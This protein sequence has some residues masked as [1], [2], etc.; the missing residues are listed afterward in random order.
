MITFDLHRVISPEFGNETRIGANCCQIP[1]VVK[2]RATLSFKT[3]QQHNAMQE[4]KA[5]MQPINEHIMSIP[6][7]KKY[8]PRIAL[9]STEIVFKRFKLS[10]VIPL[11]IT[12]LVSRRACAA[13]SSIHTEH[14]QNITRH[15]NHNRTTQYRHL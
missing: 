6:S 15:K 3:I 9:K 5:R 2:D 12:C 4:K 13:I 11:A 8:H 10:K 14:P 7:T 1:E